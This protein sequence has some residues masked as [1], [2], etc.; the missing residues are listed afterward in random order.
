D[1]LDAVESLDPAASRQNERAHQFARA[2]ISLFWHKL[3]PYPSGP[4]RHIAIG[5]ASALTGD[6]AL[7]GID[8]KPLA[9]NWRIL[10]LCEIELGLDLG[11]EQRSVAKQLDRGV[12]SIE[13]FIAMARYARAVSNG[14]DFQ[15]AFRLGLLA[16]SRYRTAK[17]SRNDEADDASQSSGQ[18]LQALQQNGLND[19]V[20]TIAVDLLIWQRFRGSWDRNLVSNMEAACAAAW[21]DSAPIADIINAAS[22]GRVEGTPSTSVALAASLASMPD[23]RGNPRARFERDLLLIFHTALSLARRGLEPVIVPI[24]EEGWSTVSSDESFALRSPMQHV[25][26]IAAAIGDMKSVGLKAAARLILAAAPAV[27]VSLSESWEQ[28]LHRIS[29]GES[30]AS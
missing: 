11:I 20:K 22:T 30:A 28:L 26:A 12:A 1:A 10:A 21:G 8:L 18:I 23:L 5:Q 19:I 9:H 6:E 3:D 15:V 7:L 4:Q 27:K 2:T 17:R 29:G 14:G 16:L 25:P 13:M 24:I